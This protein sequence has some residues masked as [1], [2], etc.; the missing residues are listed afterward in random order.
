LC[1]HCYGCRALGNVGISPEVAVL[2]QVI[3]ACY[4][5]A[6]SSGRWCPTAKQA[7]RLS[8]DAAQFYFALR[9]RVRHQLSVKTVLDGLHRRDRDRRRAGQKRP[10]GDHDDSNRRGIG[11]NHSWRLVRT[12]CLSLLKD[13]LR[14]LILCRPN[15]LIAPSSCGRPDVAEPDEV[16]RGG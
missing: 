10:K 12:Y 15:S 9:Y 11:G 3:W 16:L 13:G 4:V 7:I 14:V 2:D 1:E 6:Q 8:G 5:R